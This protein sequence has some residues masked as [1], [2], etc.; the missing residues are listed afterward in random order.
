MFPVFQRR[1]LALREDI[2]LERPHLGVVGIKCRALDRVLDTPVDHVAQQGDALKLYL[3]LGIGLR[4]RIGG[5]RMAPVAAYPDRRAKQLRRVKDLVAVIDKGVG[6]RLPNLLIAFVEA[7]V[8]IALLDSRG[9]P[10]A[11]S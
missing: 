7:R 8:G 2:G 10:R 5:V 1:A 3:V 4:M 11:K 9:G 6:L